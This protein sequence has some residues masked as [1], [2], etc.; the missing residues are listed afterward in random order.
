MPNFETCVAKYGEFGVQALIEQIE[1]TLGIRVRSE[2]LLPLEV[3][4]KIIMERPLPEYQYA[5]A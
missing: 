4:W 1:R 3:R 5:A 2:A